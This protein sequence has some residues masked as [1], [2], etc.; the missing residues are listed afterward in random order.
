MNISEHLDTFHTSYGASITPIQLSSINLD[1]DTMSEMEN[2]L[3]RDVL[4]NISEDEGELPS[5]DDL[6]I[7]LEETYHAKMNM[8]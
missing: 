4:T 6:D 8:Q 5:G 3:I 7:D 2:A 1:S